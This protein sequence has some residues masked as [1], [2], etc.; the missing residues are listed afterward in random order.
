[1]K[2]GIFINSLNK[3]GGIGKTAIEEVRALR[4]RGH[5]ASLLV[6]S[7][8]AEQKNVYSDIAD[9]IKIIY[10]TERIPR[11]L[12][13]SF[14]LPP[15]TFFSLNHITYPLL[16]PFY[17]ED[18]EF[19]IIVCHETYLAFTAFSIHRKRKIP[20]VMFIW[21][22]ISYILGRV[23]MKGRLNFL[24]SFLLKI[25]RKIDEFFIKNSSAVITAGKS[26]LHFIK[27]IKSGVFILFPAYDP[28]GKISEIKEGYVLAVTA[29]KRGKNPEYLLEIIK[30]VKGAKLIV[31]GTWI[32][33]GYKEEFLEK[34]KAEGLTS[35]VSVTGRVSEERL[36]ELYLNAKALLQTN[37][38]R[39]FGMPALEAAAHG[40][41]F[42]IPK[43]QNVCELFQEGKDGFFVVEKDTESIVKYLSLL[44]QDNGLAEEMGKNAWKKVKEN[45]TWDNHARRLEFILQEAIADSPR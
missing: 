37:D 42:V 2:I 6:F 41:T 22:P 27:S 26:H 44:V 3:H 4:K 10:L 9:D 16:A 14:K 28:K 12:R 21:D 30:R 43:G 20:Y 5:D 45:Y 1:M 40:C 39:G 35:R 18:G 32:P 31:A 36:S 25:G 34:V 33:P 24:F 23:Y 8:R 13:L 17:I 11:P 19:D 7:D 38:D 15:F 29:W